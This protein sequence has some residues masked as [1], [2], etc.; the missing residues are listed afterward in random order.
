MT[1]LVDKSTVTYSILYM[2][3]RTLTTLVVV[4]AAETCNPYVCFIIEVKQQDS[5]QCLDCFLRITNCLGV[6]RTFFEIAW[7]FH[8][9]WNNLSAAAAASIR[10]TI[11]HHCCRPPARPPP[12][13]PPSSAL[14]RTCCF[15]PAGSTRTRLFLIRL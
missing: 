12:Q 6:V 1:H 4:K 5:T 14:L 15:S 2:W 8:I 13:L 11:R 9:S 7:F 10:H 3:Q